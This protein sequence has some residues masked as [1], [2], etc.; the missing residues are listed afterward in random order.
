MHLSIVIASHNRSES[1]LD[2]LRQLSHQVVPKGVDWEVLIVDNGSSDGT[3]AM[4]ASFVEKDPK[5]FRYFFEK[6]PS[7]SIALNAGVRHAMGEVL[8]FTDDDCVP[9][10]C[11]LAS[12]AQEFSSDPSIAVVGGRVELLNDQHRPVSIRTSPHR[13]IISTVDDLF[14]LLIGCNMAI[15]RRVFSSVANF[16]PLLGPGARVPAMEDLDFLYRA[17]QRDF[18][19][20]YSPDAVVY[21]NHGR[22]TEMQIQALNRNYL[23]GRGAFYC[24]H[25]LRGDQNILKMAYWETLALSKA[26]LK[27]LVRGRIDPSGRVLST[28]LLGAARRILY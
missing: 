12:L 7:K 10:P 20:S 23:I 14:S 21:H 28:L 4:V 15:H 6:R 11:W 17:Y 8:V 27:G 16:D 3:E 26:L 9:D 25:I 1:L 22:T 24:K 19:I 2:F 18:K 5:R 13:A